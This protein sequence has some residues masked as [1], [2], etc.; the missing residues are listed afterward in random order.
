M[1]RRV[2]HARRGTETSGTVTGWSAVAR[3]LVFDRDRVALVDPVRVARVD[4]DSG[5]MIVVTVCAGRQSNRRRVVPA[6]FGW[7]SSPGSADV[8]LCTEQYWFVLYCTD[9]YWLTIRWMYYFVLD[10]TPN[11]R[12]YSPEQSR[13]VHRWR[14]LTPRRGNRTTPARS[15][16]RAGEPR[17]GPPG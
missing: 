7:V 4:R 14:D 6:L 17:S 10:R 2:E 16:C 15:P 11:R 3:W 12:R 13:R 9:M 8:L 5:V 1:G